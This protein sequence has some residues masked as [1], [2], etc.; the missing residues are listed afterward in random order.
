MPSGTMGHFIPSVEKKLAFISILD[1][2]DYPQDCFF[3]Q[4][5]EQTVIHEL[6]Y[7]HWEVYMPKH[8]N[9]AA[10]IA[11]EQAI[12]ALS[13]AFIALDRSRNNG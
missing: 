6:L 10:Y 11:A 2:I 3:S 8:K 5:V 4:D 13:C 9:V 12:D 1:P 7:A